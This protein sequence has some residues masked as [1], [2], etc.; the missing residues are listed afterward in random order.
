MNHYIHIQ[1]SY[2]YF[3][4]NVCI[5]LD[6]PGYLTKV[7]GIGRDRGETEATGPRHELLHRLPT[8]IAK[9]RKGHF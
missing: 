5:L 4:I 8:A 2:V 3:L 1:H 6:C 9:H 7:L